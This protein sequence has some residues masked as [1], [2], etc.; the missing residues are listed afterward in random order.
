MLWSRA[1]IIVL[2]HSQYPYNCV[3]GSASCHRDTLL[4]EYACTIYL[5][6]RPL[7]VIKW[8]QMYMWRLHNSVLASSRNIATDIGILQPLTDQ[9]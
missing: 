6:T 8:S 1:H 3:H 4:E 2:G 7:D 5:M 9:P